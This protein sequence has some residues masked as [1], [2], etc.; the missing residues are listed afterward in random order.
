[1]FAFQCNKLELSTVLQVLIM[2][3][4][5]LIPGKVPADTLKPK[6]RMEAG[7]LEKQ[8]YKVLEATPRSGKEFCRY[9]CA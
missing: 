3:R 4:T 8:V 2:L 7:E 5:L 1:M 9:D 6:Q